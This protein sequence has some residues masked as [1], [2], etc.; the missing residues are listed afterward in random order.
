MLCCLYTELVAKGIIT[1]QPIALGEGAL[2]AF[3]RLVRGLPAQSW[4]VGKLA[5]CDGDKPVWRYGLQAFKDW[6]PVFNYLLISETYFII[7]CLYCSFLSCSCSILNILLILATVLIS[8]I[9]RKTQNKHTAEMH[10]GGL[11]SC[12]A[13]C[14]IV[15]LCLLYDPYK[16][17]LSCIYQPMQF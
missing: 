2:F 8:R 11:F 13:S 4:S 7:D 16:C 12:I 3:L 14:L 9:G 10:C 15:A 6:P 1:E 17:S 5:G